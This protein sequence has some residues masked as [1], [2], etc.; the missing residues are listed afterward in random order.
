MSPNKN[1]AEERRLREREKQVR[2]EIYQLNNKQ[3][4]SSYEDNYLR[5]LGREL[6]EIRRKLGY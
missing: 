1:V 6:E 2:Y 5:P 4:K 3:N